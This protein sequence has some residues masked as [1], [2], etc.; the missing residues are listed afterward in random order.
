[1][2]IGWSSSASMGCRCGAKVSGG[3]WCG[4]SVEISKVPNRAVKFHRNFA[5]NLVGKL[6][7]ENFADASAEIQGLFLQEE[8]LKLCKR[9]GAACLGAGPFA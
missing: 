2:D 3:E 9:H 6:H 4:I 5:R 1:M 7:R 8:A